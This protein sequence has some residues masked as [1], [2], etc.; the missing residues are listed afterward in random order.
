[1]L[2]ARPANAAYGEAANVFGSATNASGAPRRRPARLAQANLTRFPMRAFAL[3]PA[4]P[5]R[6]GFVPYAG[7]GYAMLLPGKWNPSKEREFAGIDVRCVPP[8]QHPPGSEGQA[9]TRAAR[10]YEDNFDAVNN[11]FVLVK[12]AEKSKMEA[13]HRACKSACAIPALCAHTPRAA[14]ITARRTST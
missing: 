12:A 10:S 11:L 3:T 7:D 2:A 4:A 14:R 1:V 13:R 6:A 8:G 5:R 9:L